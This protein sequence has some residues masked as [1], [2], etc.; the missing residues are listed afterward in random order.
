MKKLIEFKILPKL[1]RWLN[2]TAAKTPVHVKEKNN[3]Y[4][5]KK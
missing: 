4:I 3:I 5:Y 1:H 2:K